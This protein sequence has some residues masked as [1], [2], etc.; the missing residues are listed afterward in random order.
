M[1]GNLRLWGE[2]MVNGPLVCLQNGWKGRITSANPDNGSCTVA[3]G[4][5][6]FSSKV[7]GSKLALL[8]GA[9]NLAWRFQR[10]VAW[11]PECAEYLVVSGPKASTTSGYG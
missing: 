5:F 11:D 8:D 7:Q 2:T 3:C 10:I 9:D 4:P 1:D 6:W